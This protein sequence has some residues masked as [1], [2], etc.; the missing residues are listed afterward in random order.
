MIKVARAV[1]GL[2]SKLVSQRYPEMRKIRDEW[3]KPVD[4]WVTT[5]CASKEQARAILTAMGLSSLRQQ[6]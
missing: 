5:M 3:R 4:S 1:P 2:I 6:P